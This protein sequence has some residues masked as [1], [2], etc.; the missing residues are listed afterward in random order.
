MAFLD[1][2]YAVCTPDRVGAVFVIVEQEMQ[3]R[4]H[5]RMHH[6]KTQVW[7]QGGVVPDGIEELIAAARFGEA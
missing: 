5:V 7:N 3:A 6:G 1:D 2:I 4:A